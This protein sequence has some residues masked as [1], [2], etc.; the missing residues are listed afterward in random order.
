MGT[1]CRGKGKHLVVGSNL[2]LKVRKLSGWNLESLKFSLARPKPTELLAKF[3]V[4]SEAKG[5]ESS[6]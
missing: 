5:P 2:L 3:N 4:P 1:L 6:C